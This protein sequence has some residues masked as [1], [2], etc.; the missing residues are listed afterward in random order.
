MMKSRRYIL[1]AC[2]IAFDILCTS[3]LAANIIVLYN[4]RAIYYSISEVPT[5]TVA[6]VLGGGMKAPGIMSEM[7][8][9]RVLQAVLLYKAG[10]TDR[11]IMSGDDGALRDDEVTFMKELAVAEGVPEEHIEID[12]HAYRT[13]LTCYRAKHEL[14]LEKILVITQ[15]FH[16]PRTLYLCNSVGIETIGLSADLK[17]YRGMWKAQGREVLAR[18]KAVLEI[19]VTKPVN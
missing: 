14:E 16:L 17:E 19:Y 2:L 9:D 6:V 3:I 13:Y 7:Q 15:N 8:T 12:P 10:K 11:L 5:S 4:P 1:I 18:V